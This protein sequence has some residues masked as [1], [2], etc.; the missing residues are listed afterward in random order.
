MESN[1]ITKHIDRLL[2]DPNNYRFIDKAEYRFIPDEELSDPRIQQRTQNF[3][4]GNKNSNI[5]DLISSLKSNGF[6]DIDQI[7]VKAVADKYLVLEG[8]RR[9][10]TLKYLYDEYR[11]GNDVGALSES[12]FKS[13]NLVEIVDE[14]PAQHLITMGLHHISGKKRWSAVNE[15]Q[16]IQDLINKHG[17][18][19]AEICNSLGISTN[20][21]RRSNRTLALI[22]DYKSS[23][24]GDQFISSMYSIFE[25]VISNPTMKNWVGW[26]D[27][28]LIA[29]NKIN[30]ERFYTWIS[31][32]E[33]TDWENERQ[34]TTLKEPIITQYRQVKEVASFVKDEKA[35]IHMEE[36]R[37][38]TEGY[39]ASDAIGEAKLRSAIDNIKSAT[40]VAYNYKELIDPSIYEELSKV[41]G[42]IEDLIP[43]SKALVFINEKKATKYF[44]TVQS[45]FTHFTINQY[46][47]LENIEVV[48]LGRVNI[49]AGGN[50]MGKTSILEA[51]YLASQLND[52]P[53]FLDLERYRGKFLTQF[54]SKWIDKNFINN[55]SLKGVFNNTS[56]ELSYSKEPTEE[57]IEKTGYLDTITAEALIGSNSLVSHIHLFASKEPELRYT[58]ANILCQ[59]AFTSPYRYNEKLLHTAHKLAIENR[60]YDI[61]IEFIRD[62]LDDSIQKIDLVN[63]EGENRFKVTSSKM[64]KAIDITKYGEG[65]QRVFEIALLLGYCKNGILCIDEIDS[66]IHKNLLTKF[67]EFIQKTALDFNVQVFL[68][69]HSKECIDAFVENN[70]PDDDLTAYSLS[71]KGEKVV[72]QFIEGNKLKQ[73]V[74]S[75]NLDIR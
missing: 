4:Q 5:S 38:I 48:R 2:L 11:K 42:N 49:F 3:L 16:L 45:H 17:K 59:S 12:D 32:T 52:I 20:A 64:E 15:A 39:T 29:D 60:Y 69:T 63:D 7:Q 33:E 13:I 34:D 50:N 9:V 21:L 18:D 37:S 56:I 72:C 41:K 46:R 65:L 1:R 31:T 47:K 43:I 61:V 23:D 70:F 75:I 67:T 62:F 27:D 58:K 36:S 28:R 40:Q 68:S 19:E 73:L 30:I 71:E 8:N 6:L 14:D 10:A 51:F 54:H 53:A 35:L 57:N 44:E 26:D 22:Q 25:A 24:Y 66:A 55:M 74:E